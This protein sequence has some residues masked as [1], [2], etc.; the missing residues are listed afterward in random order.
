[1]MRSTLLPLALCATLASFATV[2]VAQTADASA[3]AAAVLPAPADANTLVKIDN[4]VGTGKEAGVGS[5]VVVNYT[6]W[7]YKPLA[8]R[9]RGRKFDSSLDGGREP[10]EFQLG[11][12]KVIKGWDQGVVGMKVGGKRTLIIPSELAYG[13]RGAGGGSIPADADL[14]FDVELLGVR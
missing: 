6:G 7:F 11:A 12:G 14:I 3:P 1:M 10:L 4:V 2:A 5:N 9:Q 13:K 8:L